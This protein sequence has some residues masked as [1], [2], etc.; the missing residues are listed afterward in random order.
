MRY[1]S[2]SLVNSCDNL[3]SLNGI[4]LN[5]PLLRFKSCISSCVCVLRLVHPLTAVQPM[6]RCNYNFQRPNQHQTR[7]KRYYN[8][9]NEMERF[10]CVFFFFKQPSW[11]PSGVKGSARLQ[12][13]IKEE[14]RAVQY[15]KI[16]VSDCWDI[17]GTVHCKVSPNSL[18]QSHL[19]IPCTHTHTHTHTH[20]G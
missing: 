16:D 9:S 4:T 12:L 10:N 8:I 5:R 18:V 15:D 11:R 2:N 19:S 1:I 20:T 17:F 3:L 6:S 7:N 13:N 14:I